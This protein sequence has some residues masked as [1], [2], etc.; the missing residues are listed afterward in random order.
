M[1]CWSWSLPERTELGVV[2]SL[3]GSFVDEV[4][5]FAGALR[6]GTRDK[7]RD[8]EEK[9]MRVGASPMAFVWRDG[10]AHDVEI[11]DYHKG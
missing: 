9:M 1:Q 4:P 11:V 2:A 7:A 8:N 3:G 6:H 10:G 5:A